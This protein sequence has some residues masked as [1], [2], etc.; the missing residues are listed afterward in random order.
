VRDALVPN[1]VLQPIVENAIEHGFEAS[2]GPGHLEITAR[3]TAERL[4]LSAKDSGPGMSGDGIPA[5]VEGIGLK[6]VRAR[7]EQLYGD[8]QALRFKSAEGGGFLVEMEL[9]YHTRADFLATIV[10][11]S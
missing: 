7:L 11:E 3:R 10:D 5:D 2:E 8:E 6:N 1:L 4:V 9:P